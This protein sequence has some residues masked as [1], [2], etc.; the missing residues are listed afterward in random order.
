LHYYVAPKHACPDGPNDITSDPNTIEQFLFNYHSSLGQYNPDDARFDKAFCK[1]IETELLSVSPTKIGPAFCEQEMSTKEIKAA[2]NKLEDN[3]AA[4]MDC[5]QNEALKHGGDPLLESLQTLFNFIHKTGV[6]STIWQNAM[7][8]LIFKDGGLDPL[9]AA[10][11][12]PISLLSCISKVYERVILNRL[13]EA[14]EKDG[15]LRGEQADFRQHR[16][17]LEQTYILKEGVDSRKHKTRN[18]YVFC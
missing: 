15:I 7:I 16:C 14:F 1:R 11:Y 5:I 10:S 13:S 3:K 8:H 18:I 17:T 2:L 12:R 4:G 6:G 9:E